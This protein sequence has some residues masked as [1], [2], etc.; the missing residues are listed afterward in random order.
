MRALGCVFW[1]S[2]RLESRLFTDARLYIRFMDQ[3]QGYD[4]ATDRYTRKNR[5]SPEQALQNVYIP[6]LQEHGLKKHFGMDDG[7][8]LDLV[9]KFGWGW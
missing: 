1:D 6:F 7:L 4:W 2:K 5:P 3:E 8:H 9:P